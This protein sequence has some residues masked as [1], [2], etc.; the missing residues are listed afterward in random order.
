MQTLSQYITQTR[1]D[2]HIHLFDHSGVIDTSLINTSYKCVCFAD[3]AFRY[4]S[5]YK[6]DSII[7]YY[8]DFIHNHYDPQ[9][10]ILL[11][12]GIDA[13]TIIKLYKKYPQFIKGFGELKCYDEYLGEKVPYKKISFVR[14][15]CKFSRSVGSLPVYLHWDIKDD[16]DVKKINLILEDY[17]DIP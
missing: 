13:A 3:I 17:P 15:V 14:Q 1:I 12:T 7:K 9:K 6:G 2:G 5:K 16:S 4:L 11:A 10:H 8:D